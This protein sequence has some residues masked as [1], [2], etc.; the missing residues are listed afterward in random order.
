MRK[1]G[2]GDVKPAPDLKS[3]RNKIA[4]RMCGTDVH[5]DGRGDFA[6]RSPALGGLAD[7]TLI[8]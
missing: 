6:L 3:A 5:V 8:H 7:A 1:N 4:N 2:T